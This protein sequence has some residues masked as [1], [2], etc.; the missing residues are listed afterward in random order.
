MNEIR[1]HN[2][3]FSYRGSIEDTGSPQS[4]TPALHDIDLSVESG[5]FV[6]LCGQTGCG[7]TTLLKQLVPSLTP[8]GIRTG[9]VLYRG[10]PIE[11]ADRV[12]ISRGIGFVQ[13]QPERAIATDKVWHEMAF[14]LENL[15]VPQDQIRR[16]VAETASFFGMESWFHRDVRTLSGGQKQLLCLA[17]LLVMRPSVILLD[18]PLSRLDPIAAEEF[19]QTLAK[20]HRE[21]GTAI[22]AAEH[23]LGGLL[24]LC[25]QVVVME[26]G[27]IRA[28]GAP[29]EVFSDLHRTGHAMAEAMPAPVRIFLESTPADSAQT[30]GIAQ[31]ESI[32]C[33]D[34][35]QTGGIAQPEN[36]DRADDGT[37]PESACGGPGQRAH[38]AGGSKRGAC[39]ESAPGSSVAAAGDT[40]LCP[41]TVGEGRQWLARQCEERFA[42]GQ[43]DA[44]LW[45]TNESGDSI[46]SEHGRRSRITDEGGE[47]NDVAIRCREIFFKYGKN[48][49]DILKGLDLQIVSGRIAA[50]IGGN[51][52]GKSTL[53]RCLAGLETPYSGKIRIRSGARIGTL[54]QDPQAYLSG[55]TVAEMLDGADAALLESLEIGPLLEKN[56][57]DLSGG[58]IQR[59]ALAR[60]LMADPDILLL[61]EPTKGLDAAYKKRFGGFLRTLRQRGKTVVLVSHDMEFSAACAD[62]IFCLFDGEVFS[63]GTPREIFADNRF[64]TTETARLACG[65][66]DGA[67]LPEEVIRVF[68]AGKD[69]DGPDRDKEPAGKESKGK[70]PEDRE[71]KGKELK[72]KEPAGKDLKDTNPDAHDPDGENRKED[73]P[74]GGVSEPDPDTLSGG[75]PVFIKSRGRQTRRTILFSVLILLVLVPVTIGIGM[76]F[77][78]NRT[79][80]FLSLL[81]LIE[82]FVPFLIVFEKGEMLLRE[83]V[84]IAVLAALAVAGRAVFYMLPEVKPVLC[85]VLIAAVSLGAHAGFITGALAMLVSN[86]FFG[87]GLWTPW[88]MFAMGICGFFAGLLFYRHYD[89]SAGAPK[90]AGRKLPDRG[91]P[92]LKIYG[93]FAALVIYGF[94]M[95]FYSALMSGSALTPGV[96]LAYLASG[97][98]LDLVHAIATVAFLLLLEKPLVKKIRH[99]LRV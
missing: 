99:S 86:I 15:G 18:E 5:A 1:I 93:F 12:L 63:E 21:T 8:Q 32:D 69:R 37:C 33:A 95:N 87:Q 41:L 50:V 89:R 55:D 48:D 10:I 52:A 64:Y 7:K 3:S 80:L 54:L 75:A 19:V 67:I 94:I 29:R 57:Y 59:T 47:E 90:R 27:G 22:V 56:P 72:D 4:V 91:S 6:V 73:E 76:R 14:G 96:L 65:I 38:P 78:G 17:S 85:I 13:Q 81:V 16:R 62:R 71:P 58:E 39:P 49:P 31:P 98:P 40:Q 46:C 77:S 82:C 97:F 20:I 44:L 60:V 84:M 70:K 34:S 9:E 88:Q 36:M 24:P 26:D 43:T 68:N 79:Y 51:G 45:I 74:D 28:A 66:L 25:S 61:D 30:G 42:D 35:A 53:I 11:Q 92:F 23:A 2:L 83:L